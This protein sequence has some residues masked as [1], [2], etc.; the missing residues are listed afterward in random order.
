MLR[1]LSDLCDAYA[2]NDRAA[3][4]RLE[5]QATAIGEALDERGG[6]HEMLRVFEKL[7]DRRG[8]RTLEMHWGGIGD[9]Q[10]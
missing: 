9:W 1:V 4:V 5:P 10:G 6:Y 8:S 7:G 2:A 3:I